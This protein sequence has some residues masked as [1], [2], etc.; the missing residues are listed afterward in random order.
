LASNSSAFGT[1]DPSLL[2]DTIE[3]VAPSA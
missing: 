2:V 3:T 1:N